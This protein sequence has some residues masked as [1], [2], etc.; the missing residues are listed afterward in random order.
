MFRDRVSYEFKQ[1]VQPS[2]ALK[3]VQKI[4]R[5]N[6]LLYRKDSFVC[7]SKNRKWGLMWFFRLAD[8]E[9]VKSMYAVK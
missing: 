4:C 1:P 6:N 9:K 5:Q 8:E 7:V 3:I 2:D